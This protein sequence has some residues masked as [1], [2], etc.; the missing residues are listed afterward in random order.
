MENS[1]SSEEKNI[2]EVISEILK[3]NGL[4]EDIDGALDKIER[5]EQS[6]IQNTYKLYQKFLTNSISEKEFISLMQETLKVQEKSCENILKSLKTNLGQNKENSSPAKNKKTVKQKTEPKIIEENIAI[7]Q[8]KNPE[9]QPGQ[10]KP[11]TY[12]EPIE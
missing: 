6:L 7:P 12:R 4:D 3:V 2:F 9:K 5:G 11:D 10:Y 1:F 8:K